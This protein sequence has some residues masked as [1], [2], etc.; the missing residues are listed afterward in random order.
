V[1][2]GEAMARNT[3]LSAAAAHGR[4][5][6][7]AGDSGRGREV[8]SHQRDPVFIG[9]TVLLRAILNFR[10]DPLVFTQRFIV[11]AKSLIKNGNSLERWRRRTTEPG[12]EITLLVLVID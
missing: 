8:W 2:S 6:V 5:S 1:P 4:R 11:A 12:T 7:D 9:L 3:S 10:P